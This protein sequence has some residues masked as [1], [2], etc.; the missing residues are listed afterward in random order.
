MSPEVKA[1][2]ISA[3]NNG[4]A[5]VGSPNAKISSLEA[6][7]GAVTISK[8]QA[9]VKSH[10]ARSKSPVLR[11]REIGKRIIIRNSENKKKIHM[12]TGLRQA[13]LFHILMA[14]ANYVYAS[15]FIVIAVVYNYYGFKGERFGSAVVT[16][17]VLESFMTMF[18][19]LMH[20]IFFLNFDEG[21]KKFYDFRWKIMMIVMVFS[22]LIGSNTFIVY[23]IAAA[24]Q[25]VPEQDIWPGIG[26]VTGHMICQFVWNGFFIGTNFNDAIYNAQWQ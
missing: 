22:T 9:A 21:N 10:H 20:V 16:L 2:G 26:M 13:N 6:A 1:Q 24:H 14:F 7:A 17:T 12:F 25:E 4:S 18:A 23:L 3:N 15:A 11:F 8:S 19:A 5:N